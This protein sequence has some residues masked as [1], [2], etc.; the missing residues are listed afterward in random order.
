MMASE[1]RRK[2]SPLADCTSTPTLSR[3]R[4]SCCSYAS[5]PTTRQNSIIQ[6]TQPNNPLIDPLTR[7]GNNHNQNEDHLKGKSSCPTSATV[8]PGVRS[9]QI[10]QCSEDSSQIKGVY[11]EHREREGTSLHA[12]YNCPTLGRGSLKRYIVHRNVYIISDILKFRG[13]RI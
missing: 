5:P 7:S 8:L 6:S 9:Y 1:K 12:T 10:P 4:R 3:P 13:V 11:R 2:K